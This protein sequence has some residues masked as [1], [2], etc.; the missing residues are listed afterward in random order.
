MAIVELAKA[1]RNLTP[2]FGRLELMMLGLPKR[3]SSRILCGTIHGIAR[4]D[5]YTT[6]CFSLLA[7]TLATDYS[8]PAGRSREAGLAIMWAKPST[9]Y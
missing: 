6:R 5:G 9:P 8:H 1:V 2:L 3:A 7:E 4:T